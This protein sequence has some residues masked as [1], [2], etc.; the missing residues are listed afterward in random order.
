MAAV[1]QLHQRAKVIYIPCMVNFY[2]NFDTRTV[3]RVLKEG[4]AFPENFIIL[5]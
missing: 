5:Q 2:D 1:C 3:E 4:D